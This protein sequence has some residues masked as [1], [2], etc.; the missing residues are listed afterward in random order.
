MRI[1]VA[2]VLQK[3][4]PVHDLIRREWLELTSGWSAKKLRRWERDFSSSSNDAYP[5]P[6]PFGM[7][8]ATAALEK[9]I[10]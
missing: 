6:L 2:A 10:L 8:E 1:E 4:F 3:E 5:L 7:T 9:R